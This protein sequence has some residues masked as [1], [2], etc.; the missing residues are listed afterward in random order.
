M[1]I[2]PSDIIEIGIV[3]LLID[4]VILANIAIIEIITGAI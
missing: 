2:T 4:I 3:I 1:N